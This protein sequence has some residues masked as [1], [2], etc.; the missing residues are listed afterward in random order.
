MPENI[1]T[2]RTMATFGIYFIGL[3]FLY[4]LY[5]ATIIFLDLNGKKAKND[6]AVEEFKTEGMSEGE[7]VDMLVD[8]IETS[9]GWNMSQKPKSDT[10]DENLNTAV[11]NRSELKEEEADDSDSSSSS[12]G[13]GHGMEKG[14]HE[15][16]NHQQTV[17]HDAQRHLDSL[18]PEHQSQMFSVEMLAQMRQPIEQNTAIVRERVTI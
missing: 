15:A 16:Q 2:K 1:K 3:T 12:S 13:Q 11:G 5:Y 14:K 9:D 10:G 4:A 6:D 18:F 17:I 7:D 8:V